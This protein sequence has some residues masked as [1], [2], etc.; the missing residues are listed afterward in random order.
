MS[1]AP[2]IEF[3]ETSFAM[4][5]ARFTRRKDGLDSGTLEWFS[6]NIVAFDPGATAPGYSGL[7]IQDVETEE[8][9]PGRYVHRLQCLGVLGPKPN[10]RVKSS[11]QRTLDTFDEGSE[12]WIANTSTLIAVGDV[13]TQ[14]ES[15]FCV[16]VT[17]D[18]LEAGW[19][20]LSAAYKG[21][22]T[23]KGYKRRI[24]VNEQIISPSDPWIVAL[25]GGW[26]TPRKTEFSLPKVV[27]MDTYV[28]TTAPDTAAIPGQRTPPDAPA[29]QNLVI[30]GANLTWH[31]P[32]GWKLAGIDSDKIGSVYVTTYNY[33]AVWSVTPA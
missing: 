18:E 17:S 32:W 1:Q 30:S 22:I 26:A 11:Y 23:S 3:G 6:P 2:L 14:H 20:R 16:G 13:S 7:I 12:E 4:P 10:R 24:S 5:G 15:M 27:V 8:D 25:P 29:V 31:W 33:E 28:S 9:S 19:Y 21:L